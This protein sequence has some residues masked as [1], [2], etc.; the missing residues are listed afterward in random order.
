[1]A[2]RAEKVTTTIV[3]KGQDRA[4]KEV[5]KAG[6]SVD[7]LSKQADRAKR[8]F[9]DLRSGMQQAFSGD[10]LGAVQSFKGALGGIGGAGGVAALAAGGVAA[11][12]VAAA[13][14]AVKLTRALEEVERFRV[15]ARAAFAGGEQEALRFAD[16]IGGVTVRS[17]VEFRSQLA[18]SGVEANL[19][20]QQLQNLTAIAANVG[21][22]GDDAL[23]ALAQ[24]IR[25]GNTRALNSVGVFINASRVQDAYAKQLG[26][27]TTELTA[28]EKQAAVVAELQT[29]LSKN[30]EAANTV[31]ARQDKA[32]AELDNRFEAVKL[33]FS[34]FSSGAG[35]RIV[36]VLT[37]EAKGFEWA[38]RAIGEFY[39]I[40]DENARSV[41]ILTQRLND[42][43]ISIE[44]YAK[45]LFRA[46]QGATQFSKA[47]LAVQLASEGKTADLVKFLERRGRT[48][49]IEGF[50]GTIEGRREDRPPPVRRR[51]RT[52]TRTT[53][54]RSAAAQT[55][56]D[57]GGGAADDAARKQQEQDE[58]A[59]AAQEKALRVKED[60][61]LVQAR[62]NGLADQA[63]EKLRVETELKRKLREIEER[64]GSK[65]ER[66]LAQAE[67]AL[68]LR[69]VQRAATE[70]RLEQERQLAE[71]QQRAIEL[72]RTRRMEAIDTA[73]A[74]T[75]AA[76]NLGTST[77]QLAK[78][79]KLQ[80][81]L[82]AGRSLADAAR[83]AALAAS[84]G[85]A[86]NAPKAIAHGL[87]AAAHG[88][89][90]ARYRSAGTGGG[91]AGA[92]AARPS[93]GAV[94]QVARGADN[95]GGGNVTI[96][97]PPGFLIGT[98]AQLAAELRRLQLAG[99][100]TGL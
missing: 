1:M 2:I 50:E 62:L 85:A 70:A 21:K 40:I 91:G 93:A 71:A 11:L 83:E 66:D 34:D 65:A 9:G 88:V 52:P 33:A 27:T 84:A 22:T 19:T 72:E 23:T 58:K 32:L 53:S 94:D 78:N 7:G 30:V 49:T 80:R 41:P 31:W 90:A 77:A 100:G 3:V 75:S 8:K 20:A 99:A 14:A 55:A 26:K 81:A 79:D 46:R 63:V 48:R 5:R 97:A 59:A 43:S 16:T 67:A 68:A 17:V 74:I 92:N 69:D 37:K 6:K 44:E 89:A 13:A 64:G 98:P 28:Q 54:A 12:G 57:I 60:M 51:R 10:V 73:S 15:Q 47:L 45:Q 56:A 38:T 82:L 86:G 35:V 24:A 76:L 18:A 61:A 42:G 25:T 39:G 4:S 87:A 95:R 29:K 36:E 96:N